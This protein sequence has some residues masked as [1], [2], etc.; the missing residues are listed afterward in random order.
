MGRKGQTPWNKGKLGVYSDE[1]IRKMSI[2]RK[3]KPSPKKGQKGLQKAWNKGKPYSEEVRKKM[4]NSRMGKVPWNKGKSNP[5]AVGNKW[6][7]YKHSEASKKKISEI[8]TGNTTLIKS[9]TGRKLTKEHIKN[10]LR[11][12]P[13][14]SL[15]LKFETI[16]NDNSLPYKF[17]GNGDFFIERKNPDFINVNGKKI[18]VEVYY[19]KHKEKF[20][21][22]IGIGVDKW[23][24][25]RQVIFKKYG[26]E[27]IFFDET[28]VN[29]NTIIEKLK[30]NG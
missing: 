11:R 12:R 17:V 21:G 4:S 16:C 25:E 24:E 6:A 30:Q 27:I 5:A 20:G 19:R 9:L 3:G 26:W 18:A 28:Q 23:K 7:S 13:K 29:N 1:A 14:S 8:M 2:A 15:E 10:S 22:A